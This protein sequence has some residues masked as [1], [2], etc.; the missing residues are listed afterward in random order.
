MPSRRL[1]PVSIIV[2]LVAA[3]GGIGW[4]GGR[5]RQAEHAAQ[6]AGTAQAGATADGS[7]PPSPPVAA[8]RPADRPLPALDRP[9]RTTLPELKQRADAGEAAA[10]CRL[11]AELDF[12]A[13]TRMR[14]EGTADMLRATEQAAA[15]D[16]A[17]ISTEQREQRRRAMLAQSERVLEESAHCD[18]VPES[19]PTQRTGYWRSAAL[20]GNPMALRFYASGGAF[21]QENLLEQLD[22]LRV[23]RGEAESLALRAARAGDR[24]MVMALAHA[25]SPDNPGRH[26]LL[27]QA[28]EPDGVRALAF[29]L[30][31]QDYLRENTSR[32]PAG[33][34][35]GR[36]Q[37]NIDDRLAESIRELETQLDADA[38]ARAR[39]LAADLGRAPA[40]ALPDFPSPSDD[41]RRMPG[42]P[43]RAQCGES[44]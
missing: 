24:G 33:A 42:G 2:L 8:P 29:S 43:W 28:V 10:A 30:R 39:Q 19:T 32:A 20:A 6:P 5:T 35:A 26:S 18:G 9:L 37:G 22:A 7:P 17:G 36:R 14:L 12:C 40:P 21:R 1:L 4:Y 34:R 11:A 27:A 16:S 38:R 31:A 44:L 41:S 3:A 25:Y 13:Q 23:Y 15:R